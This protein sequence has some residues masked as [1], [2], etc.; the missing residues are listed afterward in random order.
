M[1]SSCKDGCPLHTASLRIFLV[2]DRVLS[3]F[4]VATFS[5]VGVDRKGRGVNIQRGTVD[6]SRRIFIFQ[7]LGRRRKFT[8]L[9]SVDPDDRGRSNGR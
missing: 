2:G 9:F 6:P 4:G 5:V 7:D 3:V 1:V 8:R